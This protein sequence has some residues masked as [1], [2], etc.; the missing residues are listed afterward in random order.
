MVPYNSVSAISARKM[1][2]W[3]CQ[4]YLA[5]VRDIT[6][7]S[8]SVSN[9]FVLREFSNVFPDDLL[10]LLPDREIEFYINVVPDINP[11]S[12]PLYRMAQ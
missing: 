7:E 10:G 4:S 3:G 5:L 2:R 8:P 1:L 9:S 11:I 12:M 6:L